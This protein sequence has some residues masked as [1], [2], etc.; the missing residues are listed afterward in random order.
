[1]KNKHLSILVLS[2]GLCM[3]F[4]LSSCQ[5]TVNPGPDDGPVDTVKLEFEKATYEINSGA[6]IT[7][8]GDV[9]G[10][11]YSFQGGTPE[12]VT[13]NSTTGEITYD[14]EGAMIPEKTYIASKGDETATCIIKFKII[15][16][17]PEITIKNVSKYFVSGDRVVGEAISKNGTEFAIE[18]SLKA[19]VKGIS[20]DP[21]TGIITFS[22]DV[23]DGTN[24]T[25]VATSKS[26]KK[27]LHLL[28]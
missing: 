6:K 5:K 17:V 20:I 16:E 3:G 21:Q 11:T 15:E 18:Y 13:L 26:V 10:V 12:G 25:V 2:A 9:E 19:E 23:S 22:S 4:A 7:V 14:E 28:Q 24:F 8:K 1:M 27:N